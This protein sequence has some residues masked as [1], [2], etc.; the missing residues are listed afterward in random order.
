MDKIKH[1]ADWTILIYANGNNELEPEIR[2]AMFDMEKVGSS[3][4]VHVVLQ[5]GRAEYKLVKLIRNDINYNDKYSWSGVRRYFVKKGSSELVGNLGKVNLA[6]PKQLY[7][8]VKW[9]ILSYPAKKYM[10][11]LSGHSYN[12]VGMMTDYSRKAPYIMGFPEMVKAIN[13]ATNEINKKIDILFLDTCGANSLELIYEFGKD[14]NHAVQNI[15]TY[16]VNG[17]IEGLPY[18]NLIK[19]MQTNSST[20]DI[21]VVIK[22]IIENLPHDL[23]SFEINYQKLRQIKQL[24][25]DK[26][27]EYISKGTDNGQ[28]SSKILLLERQDII[29]SISDK[30]KSIIIHYKRHNK[31]ALITIITSVADNL[32]LL[33]RYYQLGFTQDN[34]WSNVLNDQIIDK[35]IINT[36]NN[37]KLLPLKMS[38][39]EVYAYISIMNPELEKTKK[40]SILKKLYDYKKWSL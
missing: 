12:C 23:I 15:I 17:P 6:D 2:Q 25:H 31:Q 10:L 38:P 29:Q 16:I 30:L 22:N 35:D 26:T 36:V 40:K 14:E 1:E 4:N 11:I 27:F 20:E 37:G 8:F 32:K 13:M 28:I 19:I 5:I 9:G 18:D 39:Q 21:T 3:F 7:Y 24:F 33:T 34:C